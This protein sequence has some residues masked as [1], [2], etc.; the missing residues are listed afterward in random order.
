MIFIAVIS[1]LSTGIFALVA[2]M[3]GFRAGLRARPPEQPVKAVCGCG[4][5]FSYHSPHHYGTDVP[6]GACGK[7][8]CYCRQYSGPVPLLEID[9]PND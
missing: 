4:H 1:S 3:L 6:A 2:F 9:V 5:H 8:N 7:L